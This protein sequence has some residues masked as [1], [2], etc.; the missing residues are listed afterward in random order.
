MNIDELVSTGRPE[1]QNFPARCNPYALSIWLDACSRVEKIND[2]RSAWVQALRYYVETCRDA[3]LLPFAQQSLVD[4]EQAAKTYMLQRRIKLVRF[5]DR[6]KL[7]KDV[8][9]WSKHVEVTPYGAGFLLTLKLGVVIDEPRW[10]DRL[11]QLVPYRFHLLREGHSWKCEIDPALTFYVNTY[12]RSAPR[13]WS[14]GY[15]IE[16]PLHMPVAPDKLEQYV[17]DRIWK[18]TAGYRSQYGDKMRR[19]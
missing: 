13:A 11:F 1:V 6:T 19:L 8:R 7:L 14:V 3:G 17:L 12:N 4:I 9:S 5:L 15:T 16:C 2:T 10:S 18:P